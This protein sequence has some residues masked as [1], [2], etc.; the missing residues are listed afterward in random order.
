MSLSE[1]L[2]MIMISKPLM[3]SGNI[4]QKLKKFMSLGK[5]LSTITQKLKK[6]C[7]KNGILYFKD[8]KIAEK[9]INHPDVNKLAIAKLAI[10]IYI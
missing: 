8:K 2:S 9:R 10:I 3:L 7:I 5:C 6:Y 4:T 1:I